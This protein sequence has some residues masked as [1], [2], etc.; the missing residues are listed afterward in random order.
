M[1]ALLYNSLSVIKWMMAMIAHRM[2]LIHDYDSVYKTL[3][4]VGKPNLKIIA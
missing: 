1:S 3:F 4:K 2:Q